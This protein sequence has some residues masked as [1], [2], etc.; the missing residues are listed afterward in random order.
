MVLRCLPQAQQVWSLSS[1]YS[2]P[3]SSQV[4]PCLYLPSSFLAA[5]LVL[6]AK[7]ALYR[8]GVGTTWS[9]IPFSHRPAPWG[10]KK[11]VV[12]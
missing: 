6:G 1:S 12:S 4:Y 10:P 7:Q 2:A 11:V 3:C 9:R 8:H 5:C